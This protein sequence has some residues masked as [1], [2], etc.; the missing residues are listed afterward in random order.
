MALDYELRSE[1]KDIPLETL[2]EHSVASFQGVGDTAQS[3]LN[4][5]FGIVTIGQLANMPHFVQA[6]AVQK[7]ALESE[8]VANTPVSSLMAT[9]ALEFNVR[10]DDR[11]LTV[12]QLLNA[13]MHSLEGL[14]PAE[15]LALYDAFRVTSLRQLAH[16][17]IMIEARIIQYLARHGAEAANVSASADEVVAMLAGDLPPGN[18]KSRVGADQPATPDESEGELA[19]HV[20][21][22]LDALRDRAK[23]RAKDM[24]SG[25]GAETEDDRLSAIRATRERAAAE[26][27]TRGGSIGFRPPGRGDAVAAA[28]SGAAAAVLAARE[29]RG[30]S[31]AGEIS[32]TAASRE[33]V[34]RS[35]TSTTR[36]AATGGATRT[37]STGA[38]ARPSLRELKEQA[39]REEEA[40]A[41]TKAAAQAE[42]KAERRAPPPPVIQPWMIAAAVVLVVVIGAV[43]WFMRSGRQPPAQPAQVATETPARTDGQASSA[44]TGGQQA[45]PAAAGEAP[46]QMAGAAGSSTASTVTGPPMREARYTVQRG[47][48]LW[49]I[50]RIQYNNPLLWPDIF[51]ANRAEIDDPDLIYPGQRFLI[52]KK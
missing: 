8:K 22:R 13:P 28:R 3:L 24:S 12:K 32:A 37:P 52:P 20:R 31:R 40:T 2:L 34:R 1:F 38:G 16:N 5:Y 4:T 45:T 35:V 18:G 19:E 39:K 51:D 43:V 50:S 7:M 36:S 46:G 27:A 11:H 17:R 9:R 49:R 29:T 6:L 15:D 10:E 14:A 30:S 47:N 42:R 26:R 23:R 41:A 25:D 33:T 21:G 48:S 44:T